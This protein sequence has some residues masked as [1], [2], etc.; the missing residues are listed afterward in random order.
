MRCSRC[1]FSPSSTAQCNNAQLHIAVM[2]R[3]SRAHILQSYLPLLCKLRFWNN[4]LIGGAQLPNFRKRSMAIKACRKIGTTLAVRLT[5][6]ICECVQGEEKIRYALHPFLEYYRPRTSLSSHLFGWKWAKFLTYPEPRGEQSIGIWLH[7]YGHFRF[8]TLQPCT[9]MHPW[10]LFFSRQPVRFIRLENAERS[11]TFSF[12]TSSHKEICLVF[13]YDVWPS[14][15]SSVS[16]VLFEVFSALG[17]F[18]AI[19]G[20]F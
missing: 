17:H 13:L 8:N 7:L 20:P 18:R 15:R 2:G 9:K 5:D 11:L 10:K 19:F 3:L 1:F 4:P 14:I 6:V 16:Q 12:Q